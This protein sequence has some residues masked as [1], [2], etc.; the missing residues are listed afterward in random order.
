MAFQGDLFDLPL[1]DILWF[2]GT[3]N[4]SGWLTLTSQ[5]TNMVFTFRRGQLIGARSNDT[6]QRL[7]RRLVAEGVLGEWQLERALAYQKSNNPPPPLGTIM[8]ELGFLSAQQLE[9]ALSQ[10]FGELVFRLLIHPNGQFRFDPG[11]PDLRGEPMNV[12]VEAQV[13]DAVRRA[14][15]WIAQRMHDTPFRLNPS[16]SAETAALIEPNDRVYLRSLIRGP[17]SMQQLAEIAGQPHE[18]VIDALTRLHTSG[19]IYL[20]ADAAPSNAVTAV[21]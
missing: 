14:D 16:I 6:S 5:S 21:A 2:L 3:R 7:G 18:V 17:R 15:E 19:I 9:E 12:S 10:Q 4:K 20:D 11:V 13:F 1:T 8:V